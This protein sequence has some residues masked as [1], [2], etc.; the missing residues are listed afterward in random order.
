MDT[1]LG[2]SGIQFGESL[3]YFRGNKDTVEGTTL[4]QRREHQGQ[5]EKTTGMQ[6][7]ELLGYSLGNNR[8]TVRGTTWIQWG[9]AT[10]IQWRDNRN[11]EEGQQGWS[12]ST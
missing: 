9:G 2:T 4:V 8:V 10:R 6:R 1:E 11:I 5:S 3:G 12:G 7:W